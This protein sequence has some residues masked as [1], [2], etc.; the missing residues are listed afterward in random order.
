MC[1]ESNRIANGKRREQIDWILN[2]QNDDW[3]ISL[4][5]TVEIVSV[6]SHWHELYAPEMATAHTHNT[7][8]GLLRRHAVITIKQVHYIP[9]PYKTMRFFF[10]RHFL[11]PSA[12]LQFDAISQSIS[13][14]IM[15]FIKLQVVN[16][17]ARNSAPSEC[18]TNL[19]RDIICMHS[20]SFG[21]LI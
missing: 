13:A 16:R 4:C 18:I 12:R 9:Y 8:V 11:P 20:S 5:N 1:H 15:A 7:Y 2:V 17:R 21:F 19:K 14:Q 6:E 3:A 10:A